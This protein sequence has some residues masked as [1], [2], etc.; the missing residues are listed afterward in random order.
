MILLAE[1]HH[2][3]TAKRAIADDRAIRVSHVRSQALKEF[4]NA[5]EAW[6]RLEEFAEQ[7]SDSDARLV[8]HDLFLAQG[9]TDFVQELQDFAEGLEIAGFVVSNIVFLAVGLDDLLRPP[10]VIP[11]HASLT[12]PHTMWL[13]V[14]EEDFLRRFSFQPG[15]DFAFLVLILLHQ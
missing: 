4:I 2:R 11:G 1:L 3:K 10:Q 12:R 13:I 5:T 14:Q 6:F 15:M 8:H 7:D 9:C